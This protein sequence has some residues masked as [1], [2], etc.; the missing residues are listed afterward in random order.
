LVAVELG[1]KPIEQVPDYADNAAL[2]AKSSA[3]APENA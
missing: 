2:A 1:C 3:K